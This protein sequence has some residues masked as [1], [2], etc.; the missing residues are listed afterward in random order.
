[1]GLTLEH[2]LSY[3]SSSYSTKKG[4][5]FVIQQTMEL[6]QEQI[7]SSNDPSEAGTA[8]FLGY[9]DLE[10]VSFVSYQRQQKNQILV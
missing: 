1:M 9:F 5:W 6:K 2:K 8:T 10:L 4:P 7:G 3:D